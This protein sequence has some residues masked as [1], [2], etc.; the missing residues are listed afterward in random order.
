MKPKK[1]VIGEV[2]GRLIITGDAPYRSKDRRVFVTCKCGNNKDVLLG[3]LRRGDTVSCG[4][5]LKEV[6]TSHGDSYTRLYKLYKGML[7]RC[8]LPTQEQYLHYG[9]RG[10][11]V[12]DSWRTSYES[13][14]DW[15]LSH[16][17][18]DSLTIE[19]CNVDGNYEPRNCEWIPMEL[20]HR[21]KQVVKGASSQYIGVSKCKQTGKWLAMFKVGRSQKNLG[22]YTTELEAA[23][24]R[25]RHILVNGYRNFHMNGVL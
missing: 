21:N 23:Q 15:A 24:A 9:G 10:I 16:G 13:F 14:R 4:C 18:D 3:D 22:R 20:Q 2:Y 19:R 1:N 5:Y 6:I 25:D 11:V 7:N 8:Y 17:Y 12:C